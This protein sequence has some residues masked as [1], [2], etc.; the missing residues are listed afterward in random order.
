[1]GAIC[2]IATLYDF[3]FIMLTP[4]TTEKQPHMNG[5]SHANDDLRKSGDNFEADTEILI[6]PNEKT[7]A[8]T[9]SKSLWYKTQQAESNN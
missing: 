6:T 4:D 9:H 2:L 8:P 3:I 5:N 1:M 7:A